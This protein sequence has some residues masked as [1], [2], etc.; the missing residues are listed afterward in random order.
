MI[1]LFSCKIGSRAYGLETPES[2]TDIRDVVVSTNLSHYFGLDS[3]QHYFYREE[4]D[5]IA[6]D[7]RKFCYAATIGNLQMFEML[8]AEEVNILYSSPLFKKYI[9]DNRSRLISQEIYSSVYKFAKSEHR[10]A[11]ADCRSASHCIRM[12]YSATELLKTGI[13]PVRLKE[14]ELSICM[15]L[16]LG[17]YT[18]KQYLTLYDKYFGEFMKT[19]ENT[20]VQYHVDREWLNQLLTE[21]YI[22]LFR[23]EKI[24]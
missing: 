19:Q 11:K 17:K 4:K 15:N 23:T 14:P 12:L 20:T 21:M 6:W 3:F 9:L 18:I 8:F 16:K 5:H 2:D 10:L 1:T 7:L 13:C 24:I 22:E